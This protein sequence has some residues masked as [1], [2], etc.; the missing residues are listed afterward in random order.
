MPLAHVLEG[1]TWDAGRAIA[2]ERR[3]DGGPPIRI[4]SDG[5]VY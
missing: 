4:Q 1:G 5:T 2:K 3:P